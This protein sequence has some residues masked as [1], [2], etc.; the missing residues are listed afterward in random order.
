L[1]DFS[2]KPNLTLSSEKPTLHSTFGW[3]QFHP[4]VRY[5]LPIVDF[6]RL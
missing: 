1:P 2:A 4:G 6:D 5:A 3:M